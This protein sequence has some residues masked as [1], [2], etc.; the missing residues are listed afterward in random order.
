MEAFA[1]LVKVFISERREEKAGTVEASVIEAMLELE[2]KVQDGRLAV[3]AIADYMNEGLAEDKRYSSQAIGHRLR[4]LGFQQQRRKRTRAYAYDKDKLN[5]LAEKYG[6]RPP[7][8]TSSSSSSSDTNQIGR[9]VGD[10]VA[11]GDDVARQPPL[12]EL[13]TKGDDVPMMTAKVTPS[14]PACLTCGAEATYFAPNGKP[15]CDEHR[16][17]RSWESS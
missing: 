11:M 1:R 6:V 2:N 7:E 17:N 5:R 8:L 14:P 9:D 16:L 12:S 13:D 10:D 4:A 15:F 3:G